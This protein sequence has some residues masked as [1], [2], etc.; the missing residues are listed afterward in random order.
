MKQTELIALA[1]A[2]IAL[3]MIVKPKATNAAKGTT[4]TVSG[5]V[6]EIF[7]AAGQDFAGWRYFDNGTAI[8]PQGNYY[9]NGQKIWSAG[10]GV[11]A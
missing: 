2:G 8:D 6:N 11:W 7:G 9:L 3:Y 10:A 1:L 5:F 4:G